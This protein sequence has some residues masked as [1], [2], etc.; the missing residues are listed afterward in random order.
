VKE[1]SAQIETFLP[2]PK[3]HPCACDIREKA[4]QRDNQHPTSLDFRRISGGSGPI[5]M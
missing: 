5:K 4:D 3:Q 2:V 1:R